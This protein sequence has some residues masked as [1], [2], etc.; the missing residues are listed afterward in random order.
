MDLGLTMAR[1]YNSPW[2]IMINCHLYAD[3]PL[4]RGDYLEAEKRY[5]FAAETAAEI[6]NLYQQQLIELQV[7]SMALCGQNRVEKGIKLWSAVLVQFD[8]NRLKPFNAT[9]WEDVKGKT[10]FKKINEIG[11]EES[12]RLLELGRKM[13]FEEVLEYAMN[14]NMD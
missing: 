11:S 2:D 13:T 9:F 7:I 5:Q 10:I 14:S 12:E 4:I 6:G 1:Q 8:E 3:M